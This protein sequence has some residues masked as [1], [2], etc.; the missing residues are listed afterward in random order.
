MSLRQVWFSL[1]CAGVLGSAA[2]SIAQRRTEPWLNDVA[3]FRVDSAGRA[4][5]LSRFSRAGVSSLARLTDGRVVA[6]YQAFPNGRTDPD[7]DRVAVRFSTDEGD[8]WSE[9]QPIRLIGWPADMRTPFDPTLVTLPDGRVRLY[10]TSHRGKGP[11]VDQPAIYSAV[12]SNGVDYVVDP[13]VRFHIAGRPVIDCA[14]VIH[15][16]TFHLFAPENDAAPRGYHAVS[17]D[18]LSFTRQPDLSLSGRRWLGAAHSDGALMTFVGTA[19]DGA[20]WTA[21][22][23]D[24]Q[25]WTAQ[26]RLNVPGADPGAVTRRGGD[27]L[28]SVTVPPALDASPVR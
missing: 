15:Q 16:G 11:A 1:F 18:G 17:P 19:V 7:F 4:H 23:T 26:S 6:A 22:S 5:Q 3:V 13:G 10:F 25:A 21:T 27:W 8:A 20:L 12:S 28:V 2:V 24:G 14:V 9:P